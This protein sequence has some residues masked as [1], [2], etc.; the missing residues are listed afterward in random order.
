[1]VQKSMG[2]TKTMTQFTPLWDAEQLGDLW[3]TKGFD[4]WDMIG[5]S[6]LG[7]LWVKGEV[8]PFTN[9]QQNY[10]LADTEKFLSSGR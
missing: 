7:D 9:L 4:K 3:K 5:I 1:M 2:W 6:R 8:L 10:K